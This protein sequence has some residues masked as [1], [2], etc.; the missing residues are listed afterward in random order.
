MAYQLT[1][2]A[3]LRA[4]YGI[5]YSPLGIQY[6]SGVPYGFAPGY[7][8]TNNIIASGN[9]PRFNWDSGY[10]DNFVAPS[11]DP[12]TLIWGMVAVDPRA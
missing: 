4:A 10:P 2:K 6:W 3:V 7:K 12:N 9:I 11:K 1:N 8:G 5:F